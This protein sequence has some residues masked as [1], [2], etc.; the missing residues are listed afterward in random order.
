MKL[1]LADLNKGSVFIGD[2]LGIRVKYNFDEDEKILWSGLRLI[3]NPPCARELQIIAEEIFSKGTFEAGE[4]LR[5]KGLLIKNNVVPTIKKRNLEYSIH[6]ILRKEN[7]IDPENDIIIKKTQNIVLKTR[8]STYPPVKPNPISFSL[9][10]LNI[11]L[12]KDVFKS[13][14]TIKINYSSENLKEIEVRLLQKANLVCFCETYGAKCSKVEE[15]P[16]AIA[17]DVRSFSEKGYLLLKIPMIADPS[18]NY[19]WEPSEKE[20]WGIKYGDYTQYSLLVIGRKKTDVSREP[21]KFEVPI[22]I[23]A[24]RIVEEEPGIDLFSGERTTAPSL[25]D[26][27]SSKFQKMFQMI[28]IDS[29]IESGT[30]SPRV[31]KLKLKNISKQDLN[32]VTVKLSGLQEGLFETNPC[33]YGFNLWNKD[34]EKNLVYETKQNISAIISIIEDNSQ[35]SVRIQTPV[36]S[37][38]F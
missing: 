21:I 12:A 20:F 38:L 18:H 11:N 32:G 17:G 36:S 2:K 1:E 14:E 22:S 8:E 7:P 4:Y 19:L 31:Y 25:F 27:I 26:G 6:L 35:K 23:V 5:E 29:N 13:G 3:S 10:G 16:P 9:S 28:S 33:L 37:I 30:S 34:E 15:L 24:T